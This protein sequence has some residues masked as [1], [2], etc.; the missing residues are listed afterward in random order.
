MVLAFFRLSYAFRFLFTKRGWA[1][2]NST[3]ST[4]K[5]APGS[6]E[7]RMSALPFLYRRS[8]S[9]AILSLDDLSPQA[10]PGSYL[11]CS[12][13]RRWTRPIDATLE[14]HAH[15]GPKGHALGRLNAKL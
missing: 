4:K 7:I 11:V 12:A 2:S 5:L 3:C 13:A 8:S 10:L 9:V 6:V 1:A 15:A 14:T